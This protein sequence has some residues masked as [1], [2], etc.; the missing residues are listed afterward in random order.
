MSNLIALIKGIQPHLML[1]VLLFC[2]LGL[3]LL[4]WISK[5]LPARI[6]RFEELVERFMLFPVIY[7]IILILSLNAIMNK[8]YG[9]III[10]V[11][12][13]ISSRINNWLAIYDRFIDRKIKKT[14]S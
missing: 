2:V 3:I 7:G 10:I 1:M 5:Y 12:L 9:N 13:Y 6:L 8:T 4:S 14:N 11:A